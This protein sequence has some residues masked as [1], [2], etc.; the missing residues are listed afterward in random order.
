MVSQ[1]RMGHAAKH[2]G[3]ADSSSYFDAGRFGALPYSELRFGCRKAEASCGLQGVY[4]LRDQEGRN[5][6]PVVFL[7]EAE[8]EEKAREI[9][10]FV[11]N[12]NLVPFVIIETPT[13]IRV[14]PG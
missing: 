12:L 7:C 1:R 4:L 10:R 3:Y 6:V 8:T 11:W 2:L 9:H 5:N 13:R 14:Y